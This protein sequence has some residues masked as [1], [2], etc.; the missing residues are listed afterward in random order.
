MRR[1]RSV[2]GLAAALALLAAC[3]A[4]A[5]APAAGP[6]NESADEFGRPPAV[7]LHLIR[8][9]RLSVLAEREMRKDR[10]LKYLNL[11]VKV[12]NGVAEVSGKVGSEEIARHAL[13]KVES[14]K[15]I[16]EARPR[17]QWMDGSALVFGAPPPADQR[18]IFQAAKPPARLA[19][20]AMT[21]SE[22]LKSQAEAPHD[23]PAVDVSPVP[24]SESPRDDPPSVVVGLPQRVAA[25]PAAAAPA[26]SLAERVA[27]VRQSEGRFRGIPV[28]VKEDG[29]LIVRR[30][31]VSSRDATALSQALRRIPGV[32]EVLLSSD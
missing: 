30:S 28:D 13:G 10:V 5:R 29:T 22:T 2:L 18:T 16:S 24:K 19:P 3:S 15:G 7:A 31:G 25:P 4:Q 12:R 8:D 1:R 14:V 20:G 11:S 9:L 26:T 32:S 23:L 17:F 21:G 6:A 27:E